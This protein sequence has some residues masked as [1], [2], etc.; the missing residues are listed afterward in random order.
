MA[1]DFKM[2]VTLKGTRYVLNR[3]AA[4]ELRDLLNAAIG[5]GSEMIARI[6]RDL[7]SSLS[8]TDSTPASECQT[9]NSEGASFIDN[10]CEQEKASSGPRCWFCGEEVSM[11]AGTE[12]DPEPL[13]VCA[14][15]VCSG[16]KRPAV[17]SY[18]DGG[19]K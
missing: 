9:T 2:E 14:N 15:S 5:G 17:A 8:M 7:G 11:V 10:P 13:Y 3:A 4:E 16:G 19:Q 6:R 1:G 12:N 18:Y